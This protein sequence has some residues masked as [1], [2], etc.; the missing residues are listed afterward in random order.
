M[1]MLLAL[2]L[3][4]PKM[5]FAHGFFTINGQK[6]SKTI[7]NVIDPVELAAS[8]GADAVRFFLMSEFAFGSDGD[9]S[10]DKFKER[11]N[12]FLA[13]GLGNVVARV[14]T[15]AEKYHESIKAFQSE[16]IKTMAD[17]AW[18]GYQAAMAN[19]EFDQAI[20]RVWE[21]LSWC[22]SYIEENKP[23]ELAKSEPL[24]LGEILY[25][26]VEIIRH[27]A[28]MIYPF[29]PETGEKILKALGVWHLEEKVDFAKI[30]E[31]GRIHDFSAIK[32]PEVLFPRQ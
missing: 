21:L 31:W 10:V 7:G 22:D 13:N 14:L 27:L 9:V 8:Y 5:V 20:G 12:A 11:Y 24:K 25:N 1:G 19:L 3:P 16:N 32:K 17:Q 15:L 6:M 30:K 18:S 23:W 26:L 2:N 4:L 28:W 29:M